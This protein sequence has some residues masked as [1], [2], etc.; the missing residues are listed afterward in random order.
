MNATTRISVL[1]ELVALEEE[2]ER[3]TRRLTELDDRVRALRIPRKPRA[4]NPNRRGR[5][6]LAQEVIE[7]LKAAGRDG[8]RICELARQIACAPRTLNAWFSIYAKKM[9]GLERIAPGRY[10]Y[11]P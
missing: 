8:V 10:A 3:L 1:R 2:R 5:G 4:I 6:K 9:P 7:G 11:T